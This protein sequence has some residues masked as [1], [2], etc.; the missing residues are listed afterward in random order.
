MEKYVE[1]IG[2][3]MSLPR[4]LFV[5]IDIPSTYEKHLKSGARR[6]LGPTSDANDRSGVAF[7]MSCIGAREH[8]SSIEETKENDKD[9]DD[10][11]DEPDEPDDSEQVEGS[12]DTMSVKQMKRAFGRGTLSMLGAMFQHSSKICEQGRF[13][14]HKDFIQFVHESGRKT[15][16]R[17]GQLHPTVV[18][19]A[20]KSMLSS[21]SAAIGPQDVF[22]QVCGAPLRD[23]LLPSWLASSMSFTS[24]PARNNY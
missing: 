11:D 8:S 22:I 4:T 18:M 12:L 3:K 15:V 13:L 14:D 19:S 23:V 7:T 16:M 1:K 17:K 21:T 24:A 2:T 20:L 9:S 6:A 10:A 5:P